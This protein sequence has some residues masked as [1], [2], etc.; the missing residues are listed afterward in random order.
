MI[1]LNSR[2]KLTLDINQTLTWQNLLDIQRIK[3]SKYKSIS[4]N[5][6]GRRPEVSCEQEMVVEI[7][8]IIYERN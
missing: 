1:I 5:L 7:N 4:W 6:W 2:I 8:A 3:L